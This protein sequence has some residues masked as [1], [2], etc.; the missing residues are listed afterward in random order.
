MTILAVGMVVVMVIYFWKARTGGAGA[1]APEDRTPAVAG[2]PSSATAIQ[3]AVPVAAVQPAPVAVRAVK[4]QDT[5]AVEVPLSA[6]PAKTEPPVPTAVPTAAPVPV[7]ADVAAPGASGGPA[8]AP[9]PTPI[10]TASPAP[11]SPPRT[12]RPVPADLPVLN[13]TLYSARNPVAII[14]G[15]ALKEGEMVGG[16]EVVRIQ[17]TT[18]TVRSN[19]REYVLRLK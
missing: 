15:S 6:P 17:P 4:N 12:S 18:V 3:P 1:A 10:A 2:S 11:L 5:V 13:G 9:V 19:G 14:N 7:A 8:V 16:Y